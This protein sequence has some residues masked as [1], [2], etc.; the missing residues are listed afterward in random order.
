MNIE[1]T[2]DLLVVGL[3]DS[4]VPVCARFL[5][6]HLHIDVKGSPRSGDIVK[7]STSEDR[8][9]SLKEDLLAWLERD[10]SLGT[11][12][13]AGPLSISPGKVLGDVGEHL[14]ALGSTVAGI[15]LPF[16]IGA[17][18]QDRDSQRLTRGRVDPLFGD[19]SSQGTA[20]LSGPHDGHVKRF[21]RQWLSPE[22]L[23]FL[24]NVT[25]GGVEWQWERPR[26]AGPKKLL[27]LVRLRN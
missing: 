10:L 7:S 6:P 1:V 20:G 13:H 27:A 19:L 21:I 23:V 18:I 2:M 12:R 24:L 9:C 3:Q 14:S 4:G 25:P 16:E 15:G 8:R 17:L 5:L 26:E 11:G 22:V